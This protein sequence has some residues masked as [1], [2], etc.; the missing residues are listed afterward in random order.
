MASP[1]QP[2]EADVQYPG[3][4]TRVIAFTV[5]AALID[6]VA[7]VVGIG[8]SLILAVLHLPKKLD[9]LLIVIGGVA[10]VLWVV[11]YFVVFW[12]STGQ[13]P[14]ARLMQIRLVTVDGDTLK[15]RRAVVRFVGLILG[16][17]PLFLGY[18]RILF[19]SRRRGFPDRFARTLVIE[20]PQLSVAEARRAK[21]Q[22]ARSTA[23]AARSSLE[24]RDRVDGRTRAADDVQ[25]RR[26]EQEVPTSGPLAD[27]A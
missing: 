19:D 5:D 1:P 7:I 23:R 8:A 4:A 9:A 3:L 17:L 15:P 26:H 14:G 18:V 11:G 16:A 22:A 2:P 13:T 6:L 20:A 12:S 27:R 24:D 10:Y 25:R 21:M